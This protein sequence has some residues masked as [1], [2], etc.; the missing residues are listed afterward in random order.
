P[1]YKRFYDIT[2]SLPGAL[3]ESPLF[4]RVYPLVAPVADPVVANFSNSKVLRQLDDHLKPKT[5]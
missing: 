5:A 2:T 1:L 4:G 3:Q